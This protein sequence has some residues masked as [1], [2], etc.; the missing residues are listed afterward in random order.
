MEDDEW[1]ELTT[2]TLQNYLKSGTYGVKTALPIAKQ[3]DPTSAERILVDIS[4][5]AW[6]GYYAA[7]KKTASRHGTQGR[8]KLKV[9]L[10]KLEQAPVES[11]RLF[12]RQL[13]S[14]MEAEDIDVT[15][16]AKRRRRYFTKGSDLPS[17]TFLGLANHTAATG[18]P[19]TTTSNA[20]THSINPE[21]RPSEQ[22]HEH[23]PVVSE[24]DIY[25]G[26]PLKP[27]EKLINDQ[28]W[29]SI[30][31][32]ENKEQP[33][34][35]LADISMIFQQGNIRDHFG[36]QMEI[37]IAEEKVADLAFEYFGV[38]VESKDGVRSVRIP[39]GGKIEPDP[40]ITLRGCRRDLTGLFQSGGD[41]LRAA[42]TSPIYQ[43]EEAKGFNRTEGVS[44][45][46]SGHAK[47]SAKLNVFLGEWYASTIKKK[48]YG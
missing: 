48:F 21:S 16:A 32:I 15:Q 1:K 2:L 10:D 12:A 37:G 22:I 40:S 43:R 5:L 41:L 3:A 25:V 47:E 31:R 9:L 11:K 38:K 19:S 35:W 30:Q 42:Y 26:A 29:D 33:G 24:K 28:F 23:I 34:T 17:E 8:A 44:M 39:G 20:A 27:A 14:A 18:P 4:E 45:A 6:L 7:K 13:A 46:I 36:C